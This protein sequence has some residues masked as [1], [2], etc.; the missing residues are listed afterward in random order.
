VHDLVHDQEDTVSSNKLLAGVACGVVVG[1][2]VVVAVGAGSHPD[3]AE[4]A[5]FTV[6][7]QQLQINQKISQAAV[8]R[9]NQSLNYLAPIR[10]AQSDAADDGNNGV[11]PLSSIPGAGNGW[12]VT[13]LAPG[14]RQFWAN[15]SPTG[16]VTAQSGPSSGDGSFTATRSG[17]GNYVV[18]FKTNVTACSWDASPVFPAGGTAQ[19]FFVVARGVANQPTQVN[20]RVFSAQA[21]PPTA[22]DSNVSVQVLC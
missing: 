5:A 18:D 2:G 9:S 20:V 21:S 22:S 10:T 16:A 3:N 15:V 13:Q 14:Q 6:S 11:K 17:A 8:R 4:A 19:P 12:A 7:P 1:L